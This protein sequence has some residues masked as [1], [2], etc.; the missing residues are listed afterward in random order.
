MK[1][2]VSKVFKTLVSQL[3]NTIEGVYNSALMR[4]YVCETKWARIGKTVSNSVGQEYLITDLVNDT[5]V[6]GVPTDSTYPPLDGII[7]LPVPYWITGTKTSANREWTIADNNLLDKTPLVWLLELIKYKS[8][9]KEST[10]E[11]ESNLRVFILD[12][13]NITNFYVED[14]RE[15]VVMPMQN[16][17]DEIVKLINENRKFQRV[18]DYEINSF[19]RFGSEV[20]NGMFK[21]ILDANLSGVELSFRLVK[22]K[23][24]CKC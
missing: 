4:T 10:L 15:Q 22:Y 17:A 19:S 13:T 1:S 5:Y 23:E 14:H 9:G 2:E 8:F 16:L 11:F 6:V 18:L 21:N 7:Y 24:N 12:E 20:E 3:D